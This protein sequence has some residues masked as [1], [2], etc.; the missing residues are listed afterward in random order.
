ML[1]NEP[2][3]SERD[4]DFGE[5]LRFPELCVFLFMSKID[6]VMS[7][8]NVC[9]NDSMNSRKTNQNLVHDPKRLDKLMVTFFCQQ[10]WRQFELSQLF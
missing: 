1:P 5:I 9:M 6:E 3:G 10:I 2:Q 7:D 8:E 4:T